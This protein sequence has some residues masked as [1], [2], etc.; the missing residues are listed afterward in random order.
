M[1]WMWSRLLLLVLPLGTCHFLQNPRRHESKMRIFAQ[2]P[3]VMV[4]F[5]QPIYLNGQFKGE[6]ED[7]YSFT[8]RKKFATLYNTVFEKS[9]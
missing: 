2:N 4:S 7:L 8:R 3:G 6:T 9:Q 5:E 1:M